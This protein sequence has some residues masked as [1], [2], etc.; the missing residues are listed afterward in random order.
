MLYERRCPDVV[1]LLPGHRPDHRAVVNRVTVLAWNVAHQIY[2]SRQI[3]ESL[4]IAL[5]HIGSDV[6]FLSEF[7]D[8]EDLGKARLLDRLDKAGYVYRAMA[9]APAVYNRHHSYNRIFAASRLPFEI[10]DLEPP[11]M[12][13]F[14][15]SNFL[16][17]RLPASGMELVGLRAPAYAGAAKAAYRQELTTLLRSAASNRPLAVAGDWNRFPFKLINDMYSVPQPEGPWSYIHSRGSSQLD[18][19]VH[20]AGISIRGAP[21]YQY[22]VDARGVPLVGLKTDDA[23]S[24]HAPLTFTAGLS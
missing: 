21:R 8:R 3:P 10:G 13:E 7:V 23:I 18:Y 9:P 22:P 24:D 17:L 14:A 1:V 19:V 5:E 20:T 16:H 12:D 4:G 11:R 6:V 2:K 15:T